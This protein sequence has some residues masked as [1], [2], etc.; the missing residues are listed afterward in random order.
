MICLY[1]PTVET[2]PAL[3]LGLERA[4]VSLDLT[5]L[6]CSWLRRQQLAFSECSSDTFPEGGG[7]SGREGQQE[8]QNCPSLLLTRAVPSSEAPNFTGWAVLQILG[9]KTLKNPGRDA[10][11]PE[12]GWVGLEPGKG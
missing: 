6:Y 8:Q 5:P 7:M 9:L 10:S 3:S 12:V 11:N 2:G 1:R 4:R